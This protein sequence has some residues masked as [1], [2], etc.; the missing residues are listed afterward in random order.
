MQHVDQLNTPVLESG[1]ELCSFLVEIEVAV[2]R[3]PRLPDF[4]DLGAILD[5]T[6]TALGALSLPQYSMHVAQAQRDV[7]FNLKHRR[8]WAEEQR[9]R[10]NNRQSPGG[11]PD[12]AK[13]E[14]EGSAENKD[15]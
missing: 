13:P 8:Q 1:E 15:G 3:N 11:Q 9:Q 7:A 14:A 6:I 5:S 4:Q 10:P 12:L 2:G